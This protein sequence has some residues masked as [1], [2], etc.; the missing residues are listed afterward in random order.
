MKQRQSD[1]YMDIAKRSAEMSYA[2]RL[3]VGACAVKGTRIIST[4][5]NG[6]PSGT[7]NNCEDVLPDGTLKTK[8]SV[9]HAEENLILKAAA[10]GESTRGAI[11]FIT[12]AP[13]IHCARMIY[14]AQFSTVIYDEAYRSLDGVEFLKSV[15]VKVEKYDSENL[16]LHRPATEENTLI[17]SEK[18]YEQ[19]LEAVN[20]P[21]KPN[22]KL[23][24]L[25]DGARNLIWK[26][27]DGNDVLPQAP[28]DCATKSYIDSQEKTPSGIIIATDM[29]CLEKTAEEKLRDMLDVIVTNKTPN[30][31]YPNT[32]RHLTHH[33][34]KELLFDTNTEFYYF[35][36][37]KGSL[38]VSE[39]HIL[40]YNSALI[41]QDLQDFKEFCASRLREKYSVNEKATFELDKMEP[42]IDDPDHGIQE[43]STD[44]SCQDHP[45]SNLN[46]SSIWLKV[47]LNLKKPEVAVDRVSLVASIAPPEVIEGEYKIVTPYMNLNNDIPMG[48]TFSRCIDNI[49]IELAEEIL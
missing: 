14:G 15:G 31:E 9:L 48:S 8:D 36:L 38:N 12:H 6:T 4:S 1:Y 27:K 41:G 23:K 47:R 20:N 29:S 19:F 28:E 34:W 7:D 30:V 17:L 26:D 39:K 24:A 46:G 21:P 33:N 3:K 22:E 43:Y 40:A 11:L 45:R 32:V 2:V 35:C 44:F 16:W 10:D 42:G 49:M 25:M 13:C 5:W 18:G 37:W